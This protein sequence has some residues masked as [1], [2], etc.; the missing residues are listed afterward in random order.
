MGDIQGEERR[1]LIFKL[2]LPALS[3]AE[4]SY[5]L[6]FVSMAYDNVLLGRRMTSGPQ[7]VMIK[8]SSPQDIKECKRD[9]LVDANY[10]RCL[11]LDALANASSKAESG[12]L[13]GA[14]DVLKEC[15]SELRA[16]RSSSSIATS[17]LLNDMLE[18][19]NGMA[20]SQRFNATGR[21]VLQ[22]I[23]RSLLKQ[24]CDRDRSSASKIMMVR[25]EQFQ[26]SES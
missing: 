19:E 17:H 4:T 21:K 3:G 6:A 5:P 23:R 13:S 26:M 8:R 24:R 20:S 15:K 7:T 9:V 22:K 2:R 11:T 10:N 12:D 1:D 16:S 18:V 25:W 14:I